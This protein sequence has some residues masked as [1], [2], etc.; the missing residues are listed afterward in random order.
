[1]CVQGA[2]CGRRKKLCVQEAVCVCKELCVEDERSCV[3]KKLCVCKS[4]LS[5]VR[6][7]CASV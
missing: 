1:V 3:F 7:E 4:A 5:C 2:V 6:V